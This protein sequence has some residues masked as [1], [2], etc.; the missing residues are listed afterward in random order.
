M[1]PMIQGMNEISS[2]KLIFGVTL[3]EDRKP[4]VN[5]YHTELVEDVNECNSTGVVVNPG[6]HLTG[7]LAFFAHVL[8]QE[9]FEGW[10]YNFCKGYH[11]NWQVKGFKFDTWMM[12]ALKAQHE[13]NLNKQLTEANRM[14]V[15]SATELKDGTI[16]IFPELHGLLGIGNQLVKYF[17]NRMDL[18]IWSIQKD[19]QLLWESIPQNEVLLEE[20]R[21]NKQIRVNL[22]DGGKK[23]K[24]QKIEFKRLKKLLS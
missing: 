10:W 18:H 11:P 7:D 8:G 4:V 21:T 17:F 3:H 24:V 1:K 13:L 6:S 19:E 12:A 2:G 15:K 16:V 9:G 14:G 5:E 20:E 23:L 22:E